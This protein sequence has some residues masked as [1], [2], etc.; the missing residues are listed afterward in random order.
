M[1]WARGMDAAA[2]EM[3]L[4]QQ[5]RETDQQQFPNSLSSHGRQSLEEPVAGSAAGLEGTNQDE[6]SQDSQPPAVHKKQRTSTGGGQ[7]TLSESQPRRDISLRRS[8]EKG[9]RTPS[10]TKQSP[11]KTLPLAAVPEANVHALRLLAGGSI[12]GDAMILNTLGHLLDTE[13]WGVWEFFLKHVKTDR[14]RTWFRG[15]TNNCMGS[16]LIA[17]APAQHRNGND[18]ACSSCVSKERPCVYIRIDDDSNPVPIILP[19]HGKLGLNRF[20]YWKT[21]E[22]NPTMS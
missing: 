13:K 18:Y 10:P 14:G 16:A 19:C 8:P 11:T 22:Q 17:K 4:H 9:S 12:D 7:T 6:S 20:K 3:E 2:A 21:C 15:R 1:E 5:S